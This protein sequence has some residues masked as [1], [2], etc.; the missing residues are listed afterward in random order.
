MN[1]ELEFRAQFIRLR[2][3]YDAAF[4]KLCR[5]MAEVQALPRTSPLDPSRDAAIQAAKK[6]VDQCRRECNQARN[7]LGI[8]LLA[9]KVERAS[10]RL[11]AAAGGCAKNRAA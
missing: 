7:Q 8:F 6:K 11:S 3:D 1:S 10:F 5:A 4:R 9:R 2:A